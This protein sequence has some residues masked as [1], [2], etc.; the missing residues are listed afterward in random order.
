MFAPADFDAPAAFPERTAVAIVDEF[1]AQVLERVPGMRKGL[2]MANRLCKQRTGLGIV[3][4]AMTAQIDAL[5]PSA[6]D[7]FA[8]GVALP[9]ADAEKLIWILHFVRQI[10]LFQREFEALR[11]RLVGPQRTS[12][13]AA[14]EAKDFK[15]SGKAANV[16]TLAAAPTSGAAREYWKLV[17]FTPSADTKVG[18]KFRS[19]STAL[20]ALQLIDD[21]KSNAMLGASAQ[22][23]AEA[24]NA[25]VPALPNSMPVGDMLPLLYDQLF[26]YVQLRFPDSGFEAGDNTCPVG[27]DLVIK[28]KGAVVPPRLLPSFVAALRQYGPINGVDV[29]CEKRSLGIRPISARDLRR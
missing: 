5:F 16:N 25:T 17:N 9:A 27:E 23:I 15:A 8:G 11:L 22:P 28:Y 21:A 20:P 7:L 2:E 12:E 13:I 24:W 3:N 29:S 6:S 10:K 1:L 18:A 19:S 26:E 14:L 4:G